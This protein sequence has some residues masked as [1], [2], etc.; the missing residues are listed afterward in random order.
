M[1]HL[2]NLA[3]LSTLV[4]LTYIALLTLAW[5]LTALGGTTAA[6]GQ[7]LLREV[8]A[9]FY[10]KL[11]LAFL[12]AAVLPVMVLA[13]A[14]RTFFELR[15]QSSV[16]SDAVRVAAVAQRV[17]EEYVALQERDAGDPNDDIMV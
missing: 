13:L 17:I 3:E 4:G 16:Q 5:L 1:D 10:R 11:F 9:S 14:T 8:R 12:A 6:S 2:I 15:L 7:A